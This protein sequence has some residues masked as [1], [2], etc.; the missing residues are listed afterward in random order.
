MTEGYD[1]NTYGYPIQLL[2]V[3][4]SYY[5]VEQLNGDINKV[6]IGD[7]DFTRTSVAL[8]SRKFICKM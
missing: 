6:L 5:E 8:K 1:I 7:V 4:S 3:E 2:N